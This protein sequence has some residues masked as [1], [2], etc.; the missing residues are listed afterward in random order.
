MSL[1]EKSTI[2]SITVK[3]SGHIEVRRADTILRDG[4]AISKSYHRHVLAP[5]DDL[6]SED[7]T[8]VSIADVVWTDAVVAAHLDRVAAA[9]EQAI[10]Q[11]AADT[12]T[13]EE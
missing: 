6:S 12:P 10:A 3:E 8:V 7:P 9:Q 11:L 1:S 13:T 2:D 5:G 4:D